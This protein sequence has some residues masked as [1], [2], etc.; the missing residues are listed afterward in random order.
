VSIDATEPDGQ[1]RRFV[2]CG[3]NSLALRLV[4][5][6]VT[7]YGSEVAVILPSARAGYGPHLAHRPGVAL[8]EA[9]RPTAEA[10]RQADLAGA[11]AL[12]L[13]DQDDAGNLDAA[14]LAREISADLRVVVRMFNANLGAGVRHLLGDCEVLSE[15]AIA[16]PAFVA[17]ALGDA[18]PAFLRVTGPPVFVARR[19][20]VPAEDVLCGI[21]ISDGPDGVELLPADQRRADVVIATSEVPAPVAARR[22]PGHRLRLMALLFG[23][24]LRMILAVLAGL[25]AAATAVLMW[26]RHLGWWQ[27]GY[28]VVSSAFGVANPQP[29]ASVPEQLVGLALTVVSIALIPVLT[30]AIVDAVV[31]ARLRLAAGGLTEP[32]DGHVVVVGL[33]NVG[34]RVVQA[35]H[36]VGVT[37]VAVDQNER[38]R[39]VPVARALGV[40]LVL[41]DGTQEQILRAASVPTCR[42]LVVTSSDDVNNLEAA[43]LGRSINDEARIVLRL[44]DGDFAERVERNFPRT[45]SRS[46]SYLAAPAFAAAMLDR[47]V[48]DVISVNRRVIL[49]AE[50]SVGAGSAAE[51]RLPAELNRPHATRLL[52][53]RTGRGTQTIWSPPAGRKLVRTDRL[54]VLST[55]AGL[56]WLMSATA[57]G[58][59]LSGEHVHHES[60]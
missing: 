17:A 13:V 53:I 37:V 57:E 12:A 20:A 25:I 14:L 26:T 49:V 11:A 50:L 55:R 60:Q 46:V 51:G 34:S 3:D 43:L 4:D 9:D 29:D 15:S 40:P 28:L 36:D 8:I 33:G 39:G 27:A 6:L 52:G 16:G 32:V 41:G 5:E 19:D 48:V 58:S 7:R 18:V 47:Q 59:S 21:A 38:A 24:R 45:S 56:G 22:R 2:V 54:I 31:K 44:F 23:R 35:L 30:A 42:A 10:F 1:P